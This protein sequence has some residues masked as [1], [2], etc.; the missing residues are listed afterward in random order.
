VA[1]LLSVV[2]RVFEIGLRRAMGATRAEIAIQF[3]AEAVAIGV[4][5]A[6]IGTAIG[7]IAIVAVADAKGWQ[8]VAQPAVLVLAPLGGAAVGLI[9]GIYPAARAARLEPVDALRR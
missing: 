3:V 2:E 4:V 5:G 9:A 7:V 6:V 8:P 1:M